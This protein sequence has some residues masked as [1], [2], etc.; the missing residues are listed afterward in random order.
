MPSNIDGTYVGPTALIVSNFVSFSPF[1]S[2]CSLMSLMAFGVD[3]TATTVVATTP[4]AA[5]KHKIVE[6]LRF[7]K[8]FVLYNTLS[9]ILMYII[10]FQC[11][12]KRKSPK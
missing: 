11:K 7:T 12:L 1:S 10:S 8:S 5:A 9:N 6:E 2:S 3:F 4:D